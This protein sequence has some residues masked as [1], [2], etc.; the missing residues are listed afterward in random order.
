MNEL[1]IEELRDIT[2][3]VEGMLLQLEDLN[4]RETETYL[5]LVH[6]RLVALTGAMMLAH[7]GDPV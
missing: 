7:D 3:E 1:Q 5:S 6:R 4:G 2:A